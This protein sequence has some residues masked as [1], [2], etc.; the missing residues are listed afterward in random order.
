MSVEIPGVLSLGDMQ[1][2]VWNLKRGTYLVIPVEGPMKLVEQK[3]TIRTVHSE[4]GCQMCDTVTLR[5]RG[6]SGTKDPIVMMVDDTGMLD[7]LPINE[8]ATELYLQKCKIGTRHKIHGTVVI[9]N[10]ADFES[11]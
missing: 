8:K 5:M 3:P 1:R 7:G 10:D 2:L 6:S 11:R 9:V 4:I